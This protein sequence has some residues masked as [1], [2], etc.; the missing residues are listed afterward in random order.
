MCFFPVTNRRFR[1]RATLCVTVAMPVFSASGRLPGGGSGLNNQGWGGVSVPSSQSLKE[2]IMQFVEFQGTI[3]NLSHV[4]R[5][6]VI[7]RT[8]DAN[9]NSDNDRRIRAHCNFGYDDAMSS[10][11]DTFLVGEN[12]TE[13]VCW[14][15]IRDIVLGKY[16]MPCRPPLVRVDGVE[17]PATFSSEI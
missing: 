9:E 13:E 10:G 11:G 8:A 17:N 7:F 14:Q 12:A 3:F 1:G 16:N 2:F 6:D 5:F 15:N 4:L